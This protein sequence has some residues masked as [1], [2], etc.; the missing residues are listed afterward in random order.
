MGSIKLAMKTQNTL[1]S[2]NGLVLVQVD[3]S[4]PNTIKPTD[5]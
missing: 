3:L 5:R 4:Q 2:G 1:I